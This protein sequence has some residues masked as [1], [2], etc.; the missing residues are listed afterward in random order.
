VAQTQA[1]AEGLPI[2]F[3]LG[4][5]EAGLPWPG[6][7]FDLVVCTLM[8]T[9]VEDLAGAVREMVR[10]VRPGGYL[11]LSD[12]HPEASARGWR[13]M[14][15]L[16]TG[17]YLMPPG[18]HSRAA[19]LASVVESGCTVVRVLDVPLHDLPEGY[20]REAPRGEAEN[21]GLCLIILAQKGAREDTAGV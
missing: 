5:V 8:L 21:H 17:T 3:V 7:R 12:L 18:G 6:E 10:V 11:L 16:P 4:G 2:H 13:G 14:V 20:L 9:H 15:S 1:R 19:Y